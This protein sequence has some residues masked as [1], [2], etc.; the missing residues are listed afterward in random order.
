MDVCIQ[1]FFCNICLCTYMHT[2]AHACLPMNMYTYVHTY[3]CMYAC[4]YVICVCMYIYIGVSLYADSMYIF[5]YAYLNICIDKAYMPIHK[6]ICAFI[7]TYIHTYMC[8]IFVFMSHIHTYMLYM[9]AYIHVYIYAY[10]YNLYKAFII[11]G[12]SCGKSQ[13]AF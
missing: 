6:Y 11:F 8:I 12:I 7:Y 10:I 4:M 5:H 9:A 2:Y 1:S 13:K 3:I